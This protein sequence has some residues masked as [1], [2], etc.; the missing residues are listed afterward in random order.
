VVKSTWGE[1]ALLKCETGEQTASTRPKAQDEGPPVRFATTNQFIVDASWCGDIRVRQVTDLSVVDCFHYENEMIGAVSSDAERS[2][3]LFAHGPKA[4][5]SSTAPRQPYISI[6]DWPLKKPKARIEPGLDI[7]YS[8]EL[9]P[10]G[11]Y[12]AVIGYSKADE[13]K[14][15]RLIT[16]EGSI[17]ATTTVAPGGTGSRLRWSPDSALIGTIGKGE[18][19]V[20]AGQTLAPH[21]QFQEPYPSDLSFIGGNSELIL[22]SWTAGRIVHLP[23]LGD[24]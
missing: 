5:N 23:P 10:S 7:L 8:A 2:T 1:V 14:R 12:I 13:T 11:R 19:L 15:L 21:A 17:V 20:F 4:A 9:A 3:W 18:F 24:A 6:W 16:I 22:G